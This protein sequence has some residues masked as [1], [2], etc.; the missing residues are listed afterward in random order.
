MNYNRY[1]G[2]GVIVQ[3]DLHH[4]FENIIAYSQIV[5]LGQKPFTQYIPVSGLYSFVQGFFFSFF[6]KGLYS[7]YNVTENLF[8]FAIICLTVFLLMKHVNQ[9]TALLIAMIIPITLY[10]R[11]SLIIPIMLL[12]MLPELIE[13]RN[14][15]LQAWFLTSLVHGLYYPVFGAALCVGYFPMVIY[16]MVSYVKE[17]HF[18]EDKKNKAFWIGWIICIISFILSVPLLTGTLKHISAMSAQ[19]IYADGISRFGQ[20][21]DPL[22]FKYI[23]SIG[24]RLFWY[25]G[26]TFLLPAAVVWISAILAWRF[27]GVALRGRK[28]V[29]KNPLALLICCSFGIALMVS[30]SYTLIRFDINYLYDRRGGIYARSSGMIFATALA[31]FIFCK[32]YAKNIYFKCLLVGITAFLVAV[33]SGESLLG[34]DDNSKLY[35]YYFVKENYIFSE[36]QTIQK[37]GSCFIDENVYQHVLDKYEK[38]RSI[39]SGYYSLGIGNFGIFY[40]CEIPGVS[41][42]ETSTIK[43]FGAAQETVNVIRENKTV[44]AKDVPYVT[45]VNPFPGGVDSYCLYYLYHWLVTSGE[46]V[47]NEQDG[48]FYP[49]T[50]HLSKKDVL[51][52]N[53]SISI[54]AETVYLGKAAS[55]W[56]S[57]M[58]SLEKVCKSCKISCRTTSEDMSAKIVFSETIDG[59]QADFIFIDFKNQHQFDY[60]LFDHKEDEVYDDANWF[61]K[62]LLKKDYTRGRAVTLSWKDDNG[63]SF[64]INC[65]MGRGKLLIPLGSGRGWLLNRHSEL[66]V[67]VTQ[68]GNSVA[69]PEINEIRLLKCREV[70]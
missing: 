40:L 48:N 5:E 43:G 69:I 49:N 16:Q 42:M 24:L 38:K 19:T 53:R 41:V 50:D 30:F 45:G 26:L 3:S 21:I 65:S 27:G 47:W 12:L 52:Q 29:V 28:I 37:L 18:Q 1:S 56:G 11:V 14:L 60:I 55:S 36:D 33:T 63:N 34:V 66:S 39:N 58:E 59:N 10:N 31:L 70:S 9:T 32:K 13:K 25:N 67:K 61:D 20:A 7:Y 35:P 68:D 51:E 4:P 64:E 6:G 17:G 2:S 15:W 57:S 54:P 8:Y 46:Y 23:P 22:F 44:I 62:T